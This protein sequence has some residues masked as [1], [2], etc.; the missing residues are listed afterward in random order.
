MTYCRL[1]AGNTCTLNAYLISAWK[2]HPN[3]GHYQNDF[4][5]FQP[6]LEAFLILWICSLKRKKLQKWGKKFKNFRMPPSLL[7]LLSFVPH[8]L[9]FSSS[10]LI[11][12]TK[13]I[14][15]KKKMIKNLEN[16][17]TLRA[18]QQTHT[19]NT[20]AFRIQ[21]KNI[22]SKYTVFYILSELEV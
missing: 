22:H 15:Y 21:I 3:R 8:L 4:W 2:T 12:E 6:V 1:T 5:I 7:Q 11:F 20:V 9:F 13:K 14:L 18:C 10:H 19:H 16:E 17:T